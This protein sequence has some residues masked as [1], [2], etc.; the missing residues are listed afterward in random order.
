MSEPEKS[1][2]A[3]A[4]P[5]AGGGAGPK[6]MVAIILS[7][8]NL[9]ATGFVV[10]RSLKAQA[11][12]AVVQ[13]A[14]KEG[15]AG[16]DGKEEGKEGKEGKGEEGPVVP[17]EAFLVNLNEPGSARYLKASI[18][19]EV[20]NTQVAEELKKETRSVRDGLLR[21]LSSLAVADTLGE[22]AK[23]KIETEMIKRM[24]DELGGTQPIKRLYFTEFMVQ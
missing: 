16:K 7:A 13:K 19:V 15:K 4:A 9:A 22:V 1:P 23:Q 3:A 21:Y 14:E 18:E 5:V 11:G 6:L 24:S 10:T 12:V 20:K 17:L 8:A 2:A